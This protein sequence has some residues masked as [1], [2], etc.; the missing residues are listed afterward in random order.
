MKAAKSRKADEIDAGEQKAG[1][2]L[3]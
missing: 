2:V 1:G 3:V